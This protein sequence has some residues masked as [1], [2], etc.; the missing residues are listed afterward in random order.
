MATDH[1]SESL[2]ERI[3]DLHIKRERLSRAIDGLEPT[4]DL[5]AYARAT[6]QL[7]LLDARIAR[8]EKL[9]NEQAKRMGQK[10][11]DIEQALDA[12]WE[13]VEGLA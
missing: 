11:S 4:A 3:A 5:M 10:L 12:F 7:S 6:G 13:A 8:L 1:P 2:V 9:L